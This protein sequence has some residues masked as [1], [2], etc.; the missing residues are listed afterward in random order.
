MFQGSGKILDCTL[1]NV[2]LNIYSQAKEVGLGVGLGQL[3]LL[4]PEGREESLPA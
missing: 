2:T 4:L 3:S 1:D